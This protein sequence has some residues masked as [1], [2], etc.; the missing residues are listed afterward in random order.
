MSSDKHLHFS[1]NIYSVVK[2]VKVMFQVATVSH[3]KAS[4]LSRTLGLMWVWYVNQQILLK[5]NTLNFSFSSSI[6]KRKFV[7]FE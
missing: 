6:D 3:L 1:V 5:P 4:K 7:A 2:V